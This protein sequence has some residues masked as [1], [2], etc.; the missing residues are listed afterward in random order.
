MKTFEVIEKEYEE[1]L[2]KCNEIKKKD[3]R[4]E[5][6]KLIKKQ[7]IHFLIFTHLEVQKEFGKI[8]DAATKELDRA[9]EAAQN[10]FNTTRDAL[11]ERYK[12]ATDIWKIQEYDEEVKDAEI[13]RDIAEILARKIYN[14]IN[15]SARERYLTSK[16]K[17]DKKIKEI[18]MS[19][20]QEKVQGDSRHS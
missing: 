17:T 8:T 19:D 15:R 3:W 6:S 10:R 11:R 12:D 5:Y 4:D 16:D 13:E 14:S 20:D 7:T 2:A 18:K 1:T 9:I